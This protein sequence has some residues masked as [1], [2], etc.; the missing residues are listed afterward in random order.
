MALAQGLHPRERSQVVARACWKLWLGS[1]LLSCDAP[2]EIRFVS[3]EGLAAQRD[4]DA[5]G[6]SPAVDAG[7]ADEALVGGACEDFPS[8]CPSSQF[9]KCTLIDTAESQ[10][11]P[12]CLR[13]TGSAQLGDD[14]ERT[15]R[16][17]DDCVDG[18]CT[19]LG[20]SLDKPMSCHQL[21]SSSEQCQPSESCLQVG[22]S[23]NTG[24]CV[25]ACAF[26]GEACPAPG[27]H[28]TIGSDPGGAFIGYCHAFGEADEGQAC[29]GS[30]ECREGLNCQLPD[31]RCRAICNDDN[32]CPESRRCVP[33]SLADPGAPQL[34]VP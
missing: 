11:L 10:L 20:R 28:C 18:F 16:G 21:C 22:D 6:D 30:N 19:P 25:T 12:T 14:C 33:L 26:F 5:V 8:E 17:F 34:C 9:P 2:I 4:S 7:P 23:S 32:P 3:A 1:L 15:T 29:S 31:G 27:T 13:P 24:V